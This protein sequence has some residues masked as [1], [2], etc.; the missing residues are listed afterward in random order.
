MNFSVNTKI[1]IIVKAK[2]ANLKKITLVATAS[3]L[4]NYPPT[5]TAIYRPLGWSEYTVAGQRVGKI[6][7][8]AYAVSVNG[9]DGDVIDVTPIATPTL[10]LYI[11]DLAL[12]SIT[13]K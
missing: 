1:G 3:E 4:K 8:N 5:Y 7:P 12:K 10:P 11:F 6:S 9:K 2:D 13:D